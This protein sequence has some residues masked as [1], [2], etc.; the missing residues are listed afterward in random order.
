[1][2]ESKKNT[3]KTRG[4]QHVGESK[5]WPLTVSITERD[6]QILNVFRSHYSCENQAKMTYVMLHR[7]WTFEKVQELE[8]VLKK[9][10]SFAEIDTY[11]NLFEV[12]ENIP[13]ELRGR[14]KETFANLVNHVSAFKLRSVRIVTEVMNV[15]RHGNVAIGHIVKIVNAFD[16]L[17]SV[18]DIE[19]CVIKALRIADKLARGNDHRREEI[20]R[21]V[22]LAR[23]P[24]AMCQVMELIQ[25]GCPPELVESLLTRYRNDTSAQSRVLEKEI[26]RRRVIGSIRDEYSYL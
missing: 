7:N 13:V 9:C 15:I 25:R 24:R 3:N 1:M 26:I 20:E 6:E 23:S 10:D 14:H 4:Q 18:D 16:R 8:W 5:I 17:P 11:M 22:L 12:L 2:S 21:A 19:E